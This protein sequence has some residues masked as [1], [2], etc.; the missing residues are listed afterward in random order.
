MELEHE[1]PVEK[2]FGPSAGLFRRRVY[3]L[4]VIV[5]VLGF[6]AAVVTLME[7]DNPYTWYGR[8]FDAPTEEGPSVLMFCLKAAGMASLALLIP[9]LATR[10]GAGKE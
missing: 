3:G 9:W 2:E 8:T 10:W 7:N 4:I 5:L 6:L 1:R